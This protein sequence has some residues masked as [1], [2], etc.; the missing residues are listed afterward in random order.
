[1]KFCFEY[2][3]SNFKNAFY[4]DYVYYCYNTLIIKTT[5]YFNL[6]IIVMIIVK[7]C[8]KRSYLIQRKIKKLNQIN[9]DIFIYLYY[10]K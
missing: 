3:A 5:I 6:S 9:I 7:V 10:I 2:V 8:C 1:M 4:Y